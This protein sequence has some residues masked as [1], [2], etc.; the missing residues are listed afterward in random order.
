M[1]IQ[2]PV[3]FEIIDLVEGMPTYTTLVGCP[4]G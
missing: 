2:T 1:G 3:D 4:W